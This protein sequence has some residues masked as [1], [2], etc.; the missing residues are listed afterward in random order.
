MIDTY[1]TLQYAMWKLKVWQT[2]AVVWIGDYYY[3][4]KKLKQ[5]KINKC[6]TY[7][8]LIVDEY[9]N[10]LAPHLSKEMFYVSDR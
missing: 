3:E 2:L 5:N 9:A 4:V 1:K 10:D 6:K 7:D 8:T